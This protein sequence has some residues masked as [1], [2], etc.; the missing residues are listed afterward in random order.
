MLLH[1]RRKKLPKFSRK[2]G[3]ALD[4][5]LPKSVSFLI[6]LRRMGKP[7]YEPEGLAAP[8]GV[9]NPPYALDRFCIGTQFSSRQFAST[10]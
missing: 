2:G 4:L 1:R 5:S 3:R 6:V 7:P 9:E 10:I 8:S